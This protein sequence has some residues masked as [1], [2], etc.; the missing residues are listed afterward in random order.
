MCNCAIITMAFYVR[1]LLLL[2]EIL[3]RSKKRTRAL[4]FV[5]SAIMLFT[6]LPISAGAS[7]ASAPDPVIVDFT[8]KES[9]D[10]L[11]NPFDS[12]YNSGW[13]GTYQYSEAE[14]ALE[15]SYTPSS[16]Q[17]TGTSHFR[18]A[19]RFKSGKAPTASQKV[20]VVT[21]KTDI[22]TAAKWNI[23]NP[24]G[25]NTDFCSNISQSRGEWFRTNPVVLA[26]AV[27]SRIASPSHV[28]LSLSSTEENAKLYIKEIAFFS[29][30]DEANAYYPTIIKTDSAANM[31]RNVNVYKSPSGTQSDYLNTHSYGE[32]VGKYD[33]ITVDNNGVSENVLSLMK[34]TNAAGGLYR[35]LLWEK[36]GIDLISNSHRYMVVR[37]RTNYEGSATIRFRDFSTDS[38][39]TTLESDISRSGGEWVYSAPAYCGDALHAR[40]MGGAH[41]SLTVTIPDSAPADTYFYISEIAFF[42]S[43]E[44]ANAYALDPVVFDFK[45]EPKKTTDFGTNARDDY[46]SGISIYNQDTT[47]VTSCG[48]YTYN[49]EEDC[50]VMV[51]SNEYSNNGNGLVNTHHKFTFRPTAAS[52][53][54]TSARPYMVVLYKTN[55]ETIGNVSPKLYF[56]GWNNIEGKVMLSSDISVS[57]GNYVYTQ[58]VHVE[59]ALENYSGSGNTAFKR[60][61]SPSHV[62]MQMSY[63]DASVTV[64]SDITVSI[65]EICFFP[66]EE[67]A[68]AYIEANKPAPIPEVTLSVSGAPQVAYIDDTFNVT[69]NAASD[70]PAKI[71]ALNFALDYDPDKLELVELSAHSGLSGVEAI[72]GDA[73][74]WYTTSSVD[75]GTEPTAVAVATFKVKE[76]IAYGDK[77]S[78]TVGD[79]ADTDMCVKFFDISDTVIPT[80]APSSETTLYIANI[81]VSFIAPEEYRA[82]ASDTK[83]LAIESDTNNRTFTLDSYNF[84]WSEK[85]GAYLAIVDGDVTELDVKSQIKVAKAADADILLYNGDVNGDGRVT[86]GDAAEISEMLHYPDNT[87][88]KDK[89]R[90]GADICG[91]Y[92]EGGAYVTIADAMWALYASVGLIYD[93]T[94]PDEPTE[95][96]GIVIPMTDFATADALLSIYSTDDIPNGFTHTFGANVGKYAFD[97]LEKALLIKNAGGNYMGGYYKY[98]LRFDSSETLTDETWLVVTYRTNYT[99]NAAMTLVSNGDTSD[100]VTLAENISVSGGEYVFSTPVNL[101]TM[102]DSGDLFDRLASGGNHDALVIGIPSSTSADV[103]FYIKEFAFFPTKEDAE[104]YMNNTVLPEAGT[105]TF[106][107]YPTTGLSAMMTNLYVFNNNN[108]T[109]GD[110]HSYNSQYGDGQVGEYRFIENQQALRLLQDAK[111]AYKVYFQKKSGKEMRSTEKWMVILYRTNCDVAGKAYL[112][113]NSNSDR[114]TV[115]PDYTVSGDKWVYSDPVD[116][117]VASSNDKANIFTRLRNGTVTPLFVTL[118]LS[119]A[120]NY[121]AGD[122]F[123]IKEFLFFSS[124]EAAESYIASAP[125]IVETEPDLGGGLPEDQWVDPSAISFKSELATGANA[126]VTEG[127]VT[128]SD[129]MATVSGSV[130]LNYNSKGLVAD[131]LKFVAISFKEEGASGE[132]GKI[133]IGVGSASVTLVA[134]TSVSDGE[135]TYSEAVQVPAAV[136]NA[137]ASGEA[138]TLTYLGTKQLS[139]GELVF[140]CAPEQSEEFFDGTGDIEVSTAD[141]I[142]WKFGSSEIMSDSKV[143]L[144]VHSDPVTESGTWE[145]VTDFE[146]RPAIKLLRGTTHSYGN[147]RFMPKSA[148]KADFAA[149]N[150]RYMRV[151]YYVN[152]LNYDGGAYFKFNNNGGSSANASMPDDLVANEGKWTVSQVIDLMEHLN[153]TQ[154]PTD[155][156]YSLVNR[157]KAGGHFTLGLINAPDNAEVYISEIAFFD[158]YDGAY[159]YYGDTPISYVT[160]YLD[161]ELGKFTDFTVL[162]GTDNNYGDWTYDK[163]NAFTLTESGSSA[164]GGNYSMAFKFNI[165]KFGDN[166]YMRVVYKADNGSASSPVKLAVVNP[167]YGYET[168]ILEADVKDTDGEWVLSAVAELPSNII[169]RLGGYGEYNNGNY[170]RMY[171]QVV[172][173]GFDNTASD[174]SYGVKGIYFFETLEDALNF[175]V[176]VDK[177]KAESSFTIGGVASSTASYTA[178]VDGSMSSDAYRIF[179]D[180]GKLYVKAGS[181]AALTFAK[182]VADMR[183]L[184]GDTYLDTVKVELESGFELNGTYSTAAASEN[185]AL[186]YDDRHT[187]DK[188]VAY[189]DSID[190]TSTNVLTGDEDV[191][192]LTRVSGETF[193]ATGIGEAVVYFTDG[194]SAKVKVTAAALNVIMLIGQSNTEGVSGTAS[195][196]IRNTPGQVYSTYACAGYRYINM[197]LG[198]GFRDGLDALSIY[199]YDVF[200]PKALTSNE[201]RVGSELTY[202]L[203]ELNEGG[204]GKG[205]IDSAIAYEW[206]KQTGEKIWIINAAHSGSSVASWQPGTSE[207]DNNFWQA[208]GVMKSAELTIQDEIAAGHYTLSNF[209]YY[210][211]QGCSDNGKTAEWYTTQYKAMHDGFVKELAFDHDN[212]PAT[213]DK[214]IE[215]GAVI[216]VRNGGDSVNNQPSDYYLKG[217]RTSQYLMGNSDEGSFADIYLAGNVGDY[218]RTDADVV[219]Y[220]TEKYGDNA[221]FKSETGA[222]YDMPTT[223][224]T[225]HPDIH[226]RQAGYN[227]I[228]KDATYNLL[229]MLGIITPDTSEPVSIKLLAYEGTELD[230]EGP[231]T[232]AS[233]ASVKIV[234]DV[235]PRYVSEGVTVT[236]GANITHDGYYTF[237]STDG[238]AGT[239]TFTCGTASVTV[240][241]NN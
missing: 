34:G 101:D 84:H 199:N 33:F 132:S 82:I 178:S 204:F 21:Y 146:G 237:K 117:D 133:I 83:I 226:Y 184:A 30:V 19:L 22:T 182:K 47:Y 189:V 193:A 5:L 151:T 203:D 17:V 111:N 116:I 224:K 79:N 72:N 124:K 172:C 231:I 52:N 163:E 107:S 119:T 213:P 53:A 200:V 120:A 177:P 36:S 44:Q 39:G 171:Q 212:D 12:G 3:M 76:G 2:E 97:P 176:P 115:I 98:H 113:N 175:T 233:G 230:H 202:N 228:A 70:I 16:S 164:I 95:Y 73:F 219:S 31:T 207:T 104:I 135:L 194:T 128:Y 41:N 180:G 106:T 165:D 225:V 216:L 58:P 129:G 59:N 201:S 10:S 38:T 96:E 43:E 23:S 75:I 209:G 160:D 214:T 122:Y 153:T 103:Y 144:Y 123:L 55:A 24:A 186:K 91:V 80:A 235:S 20:M 62:I 142:I 9:A 15:L 140:C 150:Y 156:N 198:S 32:N 161:A 143:A 110:A 141:P 170:E 81:K 152:G 192:V 102:T 179:V 220:F 148:N 1:L 26:E 27:I 167:K 68:L 149:G 13:V 166:K 65:K 127:N 183:V 54:P 45:E 188:A 35:V 63:N 92:T 40:T 93:P 61:N 238:K 239:I 145:Y 197:V 168:A 137:I 56:T 240:E 114:I 46:S 139:V 208:V 6:M 174:A 90:L 206:N 241:V 185:L 71:N 8:D 227:E 88:F 147:F 50:A 60:F 195:T 210:W 191:S 7:A 130:T 159:E 18:Y 218:W 134:D 121:D 187:F 131:E 162:D 4:A 229:V 25:G 222:S 158:T 77:V 223:V 100:K 94:E 28:L 51:Y 49:A 196:S 173:M 157:I 78:V 126:T 89:A 234:P 236:T 108:I 211:L 155:N 138:F 221:T 190:I 215:F 69:V 11:L 66:S 136:M 109:S 74:G 154:Q 169:D 125:D 37:Y 112:N 87:R 205:G 86:A 42:A 217:P 105:D 232:L 64:T 118:P 67:K 48:R 14:K 85:Y 57:E 181:E 99:G 29:S